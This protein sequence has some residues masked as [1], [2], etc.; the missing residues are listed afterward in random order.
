MLSSTNFWGSA[1]ARYMLYSMHGTLRLASSG[2]CQTPIL[3]FAE[4]FSTTACRSG[5]GLSCAWAPLRRGLHLPERCWVIQRNHTSDKGK[6]R[7]RN[8]GVQAPQAIAVA[9]TAFGF[10]TSL[11]HCCQAP[12][13]TIRTVVCQDYDTSPPALQ[14]WPHLRC[15]VHCASA[16]KRCTEAC[17]NHLGRHVRHTQTTKDCRMLESIC[18]QDAAGL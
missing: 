5:A 17:P 10:E 8:Q 11:K 16:S 4:Y 2:L 9:K 1:S 7:L 12:R 15:C 14:R 6:V 3:N 13:K 18:N